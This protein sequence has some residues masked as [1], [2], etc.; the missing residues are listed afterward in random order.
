MAFAIRVVTNW[1]PLPLV[2][3]VGRAT[4]MRSIVRK[5]RPG[6]GFYTRDP[7]VITPTR[8]AFGHPPHKGEG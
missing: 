1:D 4:A 7:F 6:W 8:P 2:G 3:R 5:W